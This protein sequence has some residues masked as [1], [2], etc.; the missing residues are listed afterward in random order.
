MV[1]SFSCF[2]SCLVP[3]QIRLPHGFRM[4]PAFKDKCYSHCRPGMQMHKPLFT[5]AHEQQDGGRSREHEAAR[6]GRRGTQK[7]TYDP[8]CNVLFVMSCLNTVLSPLAEMVFCSVTATTNSLMVCPQ[9]PGVGGS[10]AAR[11]VSIALHCIAEVIRCV[12]RVILV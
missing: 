7:H 1:F 11:W 10:V 2:D 5:A 9:S 8:S 3:P 12:R 4:A 6:T